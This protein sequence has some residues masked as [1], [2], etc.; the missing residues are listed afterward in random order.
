[1]AGYNEN[2]ESFE[3]FAQQADLACAGTGATTLQFGIYGT[4]GQAMN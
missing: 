1:M 2:L 4:S 3:G